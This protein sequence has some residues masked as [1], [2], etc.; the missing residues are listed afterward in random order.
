MGNVSLKDVA[1]LENSPF[2]FICSRHTPRKTT[3]FSFLADERAEVL[4]GVRETPEPFFFY[5]QK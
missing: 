1:F 4:S 2:R 5:F 3:F